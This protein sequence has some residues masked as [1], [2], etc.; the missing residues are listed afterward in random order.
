MQLV[1]YSMFPT[2]TLTAATVT[3][4][5]LVA[6]GLFSY[7]LLLWGVAEK[8]IERKQVPAVPFTAAIVRMLRNTTYRWY[9][10]MKVPMTFL[11]QLPFQLVLLF[12]QNNMRMES[13]SSHYLYTLALALVG[14]LLS[15]PLQLFLSQRFGRKQTLTG[16]LAVISAVFLLSTFIPF[17]AAPMVIFPV[18]ICLGVSITVPLVIPD[19]IL[20]DI[21]DLDEL[22][23]GSIASC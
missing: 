3:T 21:I 20:G 6:Y 22:R 15:I 12:Y 16:F 2:D 18:G 14:A 1:V 13:L 4:A 10:L 7:A 5:V 19:A 23:T 11:G 8:G 9:L 17:H